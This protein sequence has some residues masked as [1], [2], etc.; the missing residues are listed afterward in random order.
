MPEG[1]CKNIERLN[2][3]I[4]SAKIEVTPPTKGMKC[5]ECGRVVLNEPRVLG[6]HLR[7]EHGLEAT[8]DVMM[9]HFMPV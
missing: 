5:R 1:K 6:E 3:I 9:Y 2:R 7:R 4:R 8:S